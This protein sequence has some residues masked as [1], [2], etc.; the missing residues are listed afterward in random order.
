MPAFSLPI[1]LILPSCLNDITTIEKEGRRE[2]TGEREGGRGGKE[3]GEE[4][5]EEKERGRERD[6]VAII[7]DKAS[8]CKGK[9]LV[10]SYF[11]VHA[12]NISWR[13]VSVDLLPSHCLLWWRSIHHGQ[14]MSE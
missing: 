14:H 11:P 8:Y 6:L 2:G 7:L 10:L 5:R 12:V 4:G 13:R 1:T 9:L 3:R